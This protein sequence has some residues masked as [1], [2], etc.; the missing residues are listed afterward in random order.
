VPWIIL[1]VIVFL[2]GTQTGKNLM[3]AP[4]KTFASLASWS[5]PPSKITN[6]Q[7]R[8]VAEQFGSSCPTGGA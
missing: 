2:W 7:F 3:N 5:T 6:P 4:E 1:S 8:S